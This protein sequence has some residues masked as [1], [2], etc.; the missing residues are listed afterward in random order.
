[1]FNWINF[2]TYAVI[3]TATPG[4]NNI[5]SMSNAGRVGLKK[6]Y[7]F[8]LGIW[9]GFMAVMI[10][11]TVLSSV[12]HALMPIIKTPMLIVGAGYMLYL[13]YT[14]F[15]RSGEIEE[16]QVKNGFVSGLLLQFINP[17]IY[18]YGMV[19][20]ESYILPHFQNSPIQLLGFA[21]LLATI[22]CFFNLCWATFGSVFRLLFSRYAKVTNTVMSLLLVYCAFS[23][24]A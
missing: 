24:F 16:R 2:V 13:A 10:I 17:K 9:V 8:N 22:G 20:M 3:T 1:M 14:T 21:I 4:P 12:L 23:L 19:S 7:P 11:C 15:K 6:S 18:I 5:M